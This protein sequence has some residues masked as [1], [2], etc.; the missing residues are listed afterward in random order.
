MARVL[1][2]MTQFDGNVRIT[3]DGHRIEA[4][5]IWTVDKKHTVKIFNIDI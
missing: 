2:I 4:Q 5:I 1:G 3:G